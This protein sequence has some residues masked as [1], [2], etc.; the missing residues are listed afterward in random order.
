MTKPKEAAD[1]PDV[2]EACGTALDAFGLCDNQE[3]EACDYDEDDDAE[4]SEEDIDLDDE[5][6]VP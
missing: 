6:I 3:C 1:T 5:E 4:D 2:C